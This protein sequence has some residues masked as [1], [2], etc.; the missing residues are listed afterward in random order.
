[1]TTLSRL[2]PAVAALA[3][4]TLFVS[5]TRGS[6][7]APA[8]GTDQAQAPEA[9]TTAP[10]PAVPPAAAPAAPPES[11]PAPAPRP[12]A[13]PRPAPAPEA[14]EAAK[15][16]PEPVVKTVAAGTTV[17]VEL[18]DGVS[19]K[20][21]QAGDT[22]RGRVAHNVVVD[23]LTVIPAGTA[24]TGSV[25]EAQSLRK[26]GGK[27]KLSISFDR[28]DLPSG[29]TATISATLAQEGKSETGKD[30][31]TIGGSAAAG[32]LLG[33]VIAKKGDKDKATALGALVGAAAGTAVAAKTEGQE[34]DL[35][36]GTV[37][38]VP[39]AAPAQI[40]VEPR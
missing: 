31:A 21:S 34:I 36:A 2:V 5:C 29:R 37:L 32:A 6:A 1:M 16:A 19:S 24:V 7:P 17:D 13:A 8:A 40:T 27:A 30:A 15:P 35:P 14:P 10:A 23:G 39:L 26:I 25:V 11:A 22:F 9:A 4:L 18:L 28:L 12:K 38:S 3:A 33:R 20:T